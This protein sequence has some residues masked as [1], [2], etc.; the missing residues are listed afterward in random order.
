MIL[1]TLL[2]E[3][4][5]KTNKISS[6]GEFTQDRIGATDEPGDFQKHIEQ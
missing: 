1:Y 6:V 3:L 2:T 4:I 5:Y